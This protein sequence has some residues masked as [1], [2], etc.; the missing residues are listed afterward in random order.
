MGTPG[1]IG[2]KR[3]DQLVRRLAGSIEV[4]ELS[5]DDL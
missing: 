4:V 2:Q 3:L 1:G 5:A